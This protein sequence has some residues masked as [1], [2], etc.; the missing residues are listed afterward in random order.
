MTHARLILALLLAAVVGF[1]LGW[2][3]RQA[4]TPDIEER[5]RD[6]AFELLNKLR[7]R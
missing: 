2:L 7:G 5:A 6:A 3:A 4:A 1:A